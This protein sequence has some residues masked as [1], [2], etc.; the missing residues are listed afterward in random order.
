MEGWPDRWQTCSTASPIRSS[1]RPKADIAPQTY[2]NGVHSPRLPHTFGRRGR[3]PIK[4]GLILETQRPDQALDLHRAICL[5]DAPPRPV[6]E[7]EEGTF[8]ALELFGTRVEP[9]SGVE[10]VGICKDGGIVVQGENGYGC[11]DLLAVVR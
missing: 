6:A 4:L 8:H 1:S 3:V 9:A 7:N 11:Y 10:D 2:R 5:S